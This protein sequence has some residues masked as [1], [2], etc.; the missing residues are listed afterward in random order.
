MDRQLKIGSLKTRSVNNKVDD[1][2]E[3]LRTYNHHIISLSETWHENSE[4][5][6]ITRLRRL[7]FDVLEVARPYLRILTITLTLSIM[8]V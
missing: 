2:L 5:V 6:T 7:G 8:E 3:V 4:Y 1:V